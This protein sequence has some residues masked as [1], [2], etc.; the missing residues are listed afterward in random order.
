MSERFILTGLRLP[1]DM[2]A[3]IRRVAARTGVSKNALIK[4]ILAGALAREAEQTSLTADQ[5]RQAEAIVAAA[6]GRKEP[7]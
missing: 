7:P 6:L 3:R 2:D 4:I 1:E 5:L